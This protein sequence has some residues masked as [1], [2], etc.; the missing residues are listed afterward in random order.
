MKNI[1]ATL[2]TLLS[3][4]ISVSSSPKTDDILCSKEKN[5]EFNIPFEIVKNMI[6]VRCMLNE[7]VEANLL[8][9]N[10]C[11]ELCLSKKF[12]EKNKN[13]L[14]LVF[15]P[16]INAMSKFMN[17]TQLKAFV[18]KGNI[19]FSFGDSILFNK[20]NQAY[21]L[22]N[23]TAIQEY[24]EIVDNTNGIWGEIDG[25]LPLNLLSKYG[26]IKINNENHC[27]E[28][29]KQ[30][31]TIATKYQWNNING[32]QR[33]TFPVTFFDSVNNEYSYSL[34]TLLDL[35]FAG[36]GILYDNN[37]TSSLR[38][39]IK[40][41][42]IKDIST[43]ITKLHFISKMKLGKE[44]SIIHDF[45][46]FMG[47]K[48]DLDLLIGFQ[49]LQ[50]YN[51]YF[52]YSKNYIYTL[53]LLELSYRDTSSIISGLG[54]SLRLAD[55]KLHV[56]RVDNSIPIKVDAKID[57]EVIKI[58]TISLGYSSFFEMNKLRN[59]TD[60]PQESITVVRKGD[61]LVLNRIIK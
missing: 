20:N 51:L 46:F 44:N 18:A 12:A 55:N 38:N 6:V 37:R 9:D 25:V 57:D 28:F 27:I 1:I 7:Q 35:G 16:Q 2:I 32:L 58:D 5:D 21:T 15:Y 61:T 22:S 3:L 41:F 56:A 13:E 47:E 39:I 49:A 36:K 52:D 60:T 11:S 48:N 53:P 45:Y 24:V 26:I 4:L 42:A 17:N 19:T 50:F 10:G 34:H 23:G 14:G 30:I 59:R 43:S 40:K 8:V 33:I 29:V 31:D 54:I